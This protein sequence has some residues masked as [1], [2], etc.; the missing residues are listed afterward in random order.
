M[1]PKLCDRLCL[2]SSTWSQVSSPITAVDCRSATLCMTPHS[3]AG[4]GVPSVT[5]ALEVANDGQNWSPLLGFTF[6]VIDI[7]YASSLTYFG[8]GSRLL[9]AR[10]SLATGATSAILKAGVNLG[11]A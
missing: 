5:I 4:V 2:D 10:I 9:R 6:N 11:I 3:L 7:G 1:Y 8:I